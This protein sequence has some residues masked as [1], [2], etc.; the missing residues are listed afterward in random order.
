VNG[1]EFASAVRE[2]IEEGIAPLKR[3][4]FGACRPTVVTL[5]GGRQVL[6]RKIPT[7]S[8]EIV[9]KVDVRPGERA[10]WRP[11]EIHGGSFEVRDE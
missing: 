8:G 10:A 3:A 4:L 9:T 1:D 5:S 11:I 7:E 6:I 2:A